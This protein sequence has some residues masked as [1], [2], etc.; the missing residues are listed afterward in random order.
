MK[1]ILLMI[2]CTGILGSF[3]IVFVAEQASKSKYN[4]ATMFKE[5]KDY[6]EAIETYEGIIQQYNWISPVSASISATVSSSREELAECKE[7]LE[8]NA[9]EMYD[10]AVALK[11]K[12]KYSKALESYNELISKYKNTS[13][14]PSAKQDI[15]FCKEQIIKHNIPLIVRAVD[16][17]Y[18]PAWRGS[19]F[20][21][22]L[23]RGSGCL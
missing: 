12:K 21:T 10:K 4:K 17:L 23:G 20:G 14:I 3:L 6:V 1:K 9:K 11:Q 5:K 18:V 7:Q 8:H 15:S 2:V 16:K 22:R 13:V 19:A